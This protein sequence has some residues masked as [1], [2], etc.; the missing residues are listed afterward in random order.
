M[1]SPFQLSL[2]DIPYP[3]TSP[4]AP[5]RLLSHLPTPIFPPWHS[6]TLGYQTPSGPMASPPTDVQ[7][8]HPLPH[9]WPEPQVP[10]CVFFAWW[11][12]PWKLCWGVGG[13]S[14]QLTLLF[15]PWVC[16]PPQLLQSL[17]QPLHPDPALNPMVDC[18]HLQV[19]VDAA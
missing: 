11:S 5:I 3:M 8:V 12:S 17:L 16:K 18:E 2:S 13:G 19:T 14:G 7:Q 9:I 4:P 15:P 10:P 1:V 6:P